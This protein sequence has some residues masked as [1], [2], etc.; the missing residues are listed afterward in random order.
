MDKEMYKEMRKEMD[1]EMRK[2]MY[3]EWD[4]ELDEHTAELHRLW[5]NTFTYDY[6]DSPDEDP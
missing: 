6:V 1:K 2:E 5:R 4:K 3:E